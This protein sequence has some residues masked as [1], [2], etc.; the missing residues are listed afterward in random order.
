M[1]TIYR[2][3]LVAGCLWFYSLSSEASEKFALLPFLM[4]GKTILFTVDPEPSEENPNHGKSYRMS[5]TANN[6]S[7]MMKDERIGVLGN[8]KYSRYG[9]RENPL[10][11][12]TARE[13]YDGEPS[14][15]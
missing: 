15:F 12:I 4:D 8:Y 1:K 11:R 9:S 3:S 13:T 5:F 2:I 14:G 7:Y 10:A 6:Y